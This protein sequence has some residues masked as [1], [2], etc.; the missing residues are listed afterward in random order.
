MLNIVSSLAVLVCTGELHINS[1]TADAFQIGGNALVSKLHAR[2]SF[3]ESMFANCDKQVRVS[4]QIKDT[5]AHMLAAHAPPAT[6]KQ[7]AN[8]INGG[9]LQDG[10]VIA[11]LRAEYLRHKNG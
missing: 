8:N 9:T 5:C 4:R 7:V 10:T 2:I 6:I 1:A 3:L 11:I